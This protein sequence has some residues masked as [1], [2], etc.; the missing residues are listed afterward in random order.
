M[1]AGPPPAESAT[2][3]PES[4][5]DLGQEQVKR[6][7]KRIAVV[8]PRELKELPYPLDQVTLALGKRQAPVAQ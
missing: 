2:A 5:A 8:R 6:L 7:L 3:S 4:P 1:W